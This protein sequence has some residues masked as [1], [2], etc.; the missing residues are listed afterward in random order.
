MCSGGN[1]LRCAEKFVWFSQY[2]QFFIGDFFSF[3]D[4]GILDDQ[5][6]DGRQ[7]FN[8]QFTVNILGFSIQ[9][10]ENRTCKKKSNEFNAKIV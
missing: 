7:H 1:L 6:S 4:S 3:P 10:I 9:F 5:L 2:Q 8:H